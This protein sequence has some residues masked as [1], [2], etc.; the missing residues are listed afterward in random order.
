[1]IYYYLQNRTEKYLI[2][3]EHLWALPNVHKLKQHSCHPKPLLPRIRAHHKCRWSTG[4][5][6]LP[7][8]KF[9]QVTH[10]QMQI[11][12]FP[13]ITTDPSMDLKMLQVPVGWPVLNKNGTAN[14]FGY[15]SAF[16]QAQECPNRWVLGEIYLK[17]FRTFI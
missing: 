5:N 17:W 6:R 8:K 1:M 13:Q 9:P 11:I 7:A 16:K 3:G 10:L 15:L 12:C 2:K 14:I 4:I